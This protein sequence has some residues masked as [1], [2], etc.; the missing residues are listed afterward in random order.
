MNQKV[1][2]MARFTIKQLAQQRNIHNA[3]ELSRATGIA[4]S[5]AREIWRESEDINIETRTLKRIADAW[6]VRIVDLFE[7]DKPAEGK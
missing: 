7:D 5:L 4:Y 1:M 3:M 6:G 2:S